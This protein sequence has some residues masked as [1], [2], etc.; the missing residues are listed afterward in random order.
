MAR[1]SDGYLN[2]RRTSD[3]R[4]SV[5]RLSRRALTPGRRAEARPTTAAD[6]ASAAQLACLLEASAPKPGNVAPHARTHFRDTRYEHFLASAAAIGPAMLLARRHSL[7]S[8]ILAACTATA[9]W[10]R[11]N[12]NL[13]IIL[14]LA[15]LARA[16][17]DPRPGTLRERSS[18]ERRVGAELWPA[19]GRSG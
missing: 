12:T 5:R 15:P 1:A 14:L 11:A 10:T 6:V 4:S 17:L 18:E 16:A 7:G 3:R 9:R 13:G 8:T 19:G 2:R